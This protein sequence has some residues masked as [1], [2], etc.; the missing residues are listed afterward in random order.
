MVHFM[1]RYLPSLPAGAPPSLQA[2]A[3]RLIS[4]NATPRRTILVVEDDFFLH[5]AVVDVLRRHGFTVFAALDTNKAWDYLQSEAIDLLFTDIR[6]PGFVDGLALAALI[7]KQRPEM[8]I[9]VASGHSPAGN[10]R[11]T[12]DEWLCKPYQYDYMVRVINRL[13]GE[14]AAP[15]N[16]RPFTRGKGPGRRRPIAAP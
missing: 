3:T 15:A 16:P 1:S 11:A 10:D 6:L 13:L 4:V 9:V 5:S 12:A 7:R 8:K 14:G 2:D